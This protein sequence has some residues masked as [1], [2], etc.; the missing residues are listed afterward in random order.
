MMLIWLFVAC[1]GQEPPRWLPIDVIEVEGSTTIDLAGSIEDDGTDIVFWPTAEDGVEASVAGST[2]T[3]TGAEGFDGYTR[4]DVTA[5]DACGN[6]ATTTLSVHV[7]AAP[8]GS[9]EDCPVPVTWTGTASSVSIA[10]SFSEWE[11]VALTNDGGTWSTELSLK[12]GGYPYK[13]IVD[14]TWACSAQSPYFQCDEGQDWDPACTGG[15][16]C[17]SMLVVEDCG[18]PSITLDSLAIDR[19]ALGVTAHATASG[20][21]TNPWATLD[22]AS[23]DAWDGTAFSYSIAGLDAGRHTLRFGADNAELV[24]IPFWL[25]GRGWDEGSMYFVFV[26]RFDDGDPS[27]DSAEG[28]TV[29]YAGGDWQGVIDRLAYL[30]GLGV[31]TI[32]L[33]APLDNAQ[34]AWDGQCDETYSAYHGYWP[35][36]EGLEEHFGDDATLRELIDAAHQRNIRVL[37]DLVANHVHQ[38]HAWYTDHPDWFNDEHICEEDDDGDGV[39]NWDQRPE[40]CWFAEYLPDLNYRLTEPTLVS[41]DDAID[42]AKDYDIDGM[43]VDAVKHLP[44]HYWWDLQT[45]VRND[46]EHRDVGGD[47]DLRLVGETFDGADKIASY[48]GDNLL[49]AQFDFPLYYAIVQAFARDEIGLSN[50]DGSLASVFASSQASYGGALMS[51]FLGNHDVERFIAQANGEVGNLGGDSPCDDNGLVASDESP[52][53]VEP[54]ERLALAWA[55]LLTSEGQPLIYYGDEIGL[56]GYADPDNRQPMRFDGLSANEAMVLDHVERLGQAR[57]DHPAFSHGARTTWWE[58]EADLWAYA[59]TEGDDA[60]LVALNRSASERSLSNGLA[61]AGLTQ[62]TWEDILTGDQFTSAGD[63]LSFTVPGRGARVLV[64]R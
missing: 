46:L 47:E 28:A 26:D 19:A 59:R 64:R 8:V 40:T 27:N 5:A 56:P 6:E 61:F 20:T 10:G 29:D 2:L 52:T 13:F 42:F 23:I 45:R 15:N 32:W 58:N 33:T 53:S 1:C 12:A 63:T 41:I 54:Y 48:L 50:G 30:D 60:V 62:G 11:P 49:D 31:T 43:R 14:G 21:L 38:D 44:T 7:T 34:G 51:T 36:S 25:D 35:A 9:G 37:V 22:G 39:V 4:V 24:H 55:F 57:R 17:N 16:S 3:L 18:L